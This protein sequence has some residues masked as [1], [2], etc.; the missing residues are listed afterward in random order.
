MYN[1]DLMK[2]DLA[3][4][5]YV[6]TPD[7]VSQQLNINLDE[8]VLANGFVGDVA[9]EVEKIL[10]RVSMLIYNWIYSICAFHYETEK[11]LAMNELARQPLMDAMG[12]QLEYMINDGDLS[13]YSGVDIESKTAM[14]RNNLDKV[15]ISRQ[16][17]LIIANA[18][19]VKVAY[20]LGDRDIKPTYEE[21]G[22]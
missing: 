12:E 21:D 2:Y 10:N 22:Y 14:D 4:H 15:V 16:A 17:K 19:I 20:Y 8:V 11:E 18:D 6:L 7:Y 5:R 3:R 9:N 1:D 13:L